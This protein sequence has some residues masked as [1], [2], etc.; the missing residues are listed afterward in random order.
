MKTERKVIFQ[1]RFLWPLQI[2]TSP[3]PDPVVCPCNAQLSCFAYWLL[4]AL[5][6][7]GEAR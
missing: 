7:E 3:F 5:K 1:E 4:L 6:D 2:D